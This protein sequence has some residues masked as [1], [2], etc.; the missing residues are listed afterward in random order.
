MGFGRGWELERGIQEPPGRLAG[1]DGLPATGVRPQ[2]C[3]VSGM[4]QSG[5]ATSA[6]LVMERRAMT[7]SILVCIDNLRDTTLHL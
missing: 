2:L 4:T 5:S 3:R 1:S 7:F 6:L